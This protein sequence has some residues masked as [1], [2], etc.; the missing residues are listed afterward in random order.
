[1]LFTL[2]LLVQ[3]ELRMATIMAE[4]NVPTDVSDALLEQ[5][6]RAQM[7][8]SAVSLTLMVISVF[9]GVKLSHRI[10]GP[11]V[12]IQ[13]HV[14][15]L[16]NGQYASRVHLRDNDH[17]IPLGEDLNELAEVLGKEKS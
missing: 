5:L 10:Y 15:N 12:Q 6:G 4:A 7:Q 16:I 2:Y 9:L 14:V 11:I 17:F 1:M 3:L 13:K 8:V